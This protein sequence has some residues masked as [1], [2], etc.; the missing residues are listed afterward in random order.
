[1]VN[2]A[3][4][5]AKIGAL[6]AALDALSAER[7]KAVDAVTRAEHAGKVPDVLKAEGTRD[8]AARLI[9]VKRAELANLQAALPSLELAE[10]R[11][12]DVDELR[13]VL[14]RRDELLAAFTLAVE[15]LE[16]TIAAPLA[17]VHELHE[18]A[19]ALHRDVHDRVRRLANVYLTE[20]HKDSYAWA[21][22]ARERVAA[23]FEPYGL[24]VPELFT[25]RDVL[26]QTSLDVQR[27]LPVA[28]TVAN[29]VRAEMLERQGRELDVTPA[30]FVADVEA[31]WLTPLPMRRV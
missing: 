16:A 20:P 10:R 13:A 21:K 14:A 30:P 17:K 31:F 29:F 24:T 23:C 26:P 11:A 15:E 19:A 2:A 9:A 12:A 7:D 5:R 3:E 22:T 27:E 18:Q 28:E 25:T 8:T 1:M 4:H 6:T